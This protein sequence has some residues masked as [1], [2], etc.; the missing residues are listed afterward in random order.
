MAGFARC[1]SSHAAVVAFALLWLGSAGCVSD[2]DPITGTTS[3]RVELTSPTDLGSIDSRLADTARTVTLTVTALNAQGEVDTDF[4]GTG[5]IYV[6]FLG[7]LSPD[8]NDAIALETVP[9]T[10]GVSGAV[11][12]DFPPV[13]G[14]TFLWVEHTRGDD[15]SFAT[16]T[17]D[18]LWYRDPFIEDTQRP[19]DEMSLDAL[20][21]SPLEQKQVTVTS[22][23]YGDRGRLIVTGTYAQGYTLADVQCADAAGTPPCVSGDYDFVFIFTFSRPEDEDG[24]PLAQGQVI[25]GFGGSIG[26][27]NGLTE[28]NFPQSFASSTDTFP[29]MLPPPVKIDPSWLNTR[30]EMERLEAGLIEIS[31]TLC[32]LDDD[33]DTFAQW[34]LD[35]GNGCEDPIN[36]ISKGQISDFDPT[37]YVGQTMPSI[38]GTL[39]PVNIGSFNVWI[40]YPRVLSDI[41]LP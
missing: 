17:S 12:L 23:R 2:R 15:P 21:S 7:G 27:F 26:E 20:Q 38:V 25:D 24:R 40:M 10:S 29:A 1:S 18:T 19:E 33:F 8:I 11:T 34:K 41:T 13:F 31:G 30:I 5:D 35:I 39:R 6:H 37:N 9:I 36:I 3:L 32:P 14:P 22:S 28:V 4:S 16:G